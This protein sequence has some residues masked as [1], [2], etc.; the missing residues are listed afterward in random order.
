MIF[1]NLH[2]V[3][4]ELNCV[5]SSINILITSAGCPAMHPT[6]RSSDDEEISADWKVVKAPAGNTNEFTGTQSL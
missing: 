6:T 1:T 4:S 2:S 3:T 5:T